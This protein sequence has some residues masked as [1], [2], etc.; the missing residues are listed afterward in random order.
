MPAYYVHHFSPFIVE[1]WHGVGIRWYGTAYVLG[2]IFGYQ[3]FAWLARHGYS[4]LPVSKVADFITGACLWGVLVGG[5]L[6]YA[7]FY[8][9]DGVLHDPLRIFRVWEGGMA[10]HGGVLG[11]VFYLLWYSRR[12]KVSML[13]LGDNITVVATIGVFF[14][15]IANF[16]NGELFGRIT[17]VPWAIQFPKELYQ[18]DG[19]AKKAVEAC[20]AIDPKLITPEAIVDATQKS[21]PVR[22]ALSEILNPR[23]PSQLYEAGLEGLFLFVSLWLL[24]TKTRVPEGVV[25]G[26]FFILYAC[27]RIFGEMF[28][29]PD[30]ATAMLFGIELTRGQFLSLFMILLGIGFVVVA[31][32][33]GKPSPRPAATAAK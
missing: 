17:Q 29:E 26:T 16:I 24:R 6:G 13:G 3:L 23:H 33:R 2:F 7:L 1:F 14:G 10:S 27:V 20:S 21:E 18:D 15:R 30:A 31:Y 5:R 19:L 8:D 22:Q 12:H 25:T 28:R 9:F 11:I 4:E 32:K